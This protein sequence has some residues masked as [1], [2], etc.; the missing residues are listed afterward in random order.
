MA[1]IVVAVN[2][3][4]CAPLQM[5]SSATISTEDWMAVPPN[6][7]EP[8]RPALVAAQHISR[9]SAKK[10]PGPRAKG[11]QLVDSGG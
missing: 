9:T 1:G 6:R 2:R 4:L 3:L 8:E 7:N 11:R 5:A 10:E